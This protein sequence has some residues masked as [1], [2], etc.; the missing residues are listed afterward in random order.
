MTRSALRKAENRLLVLVVSFT[1]VGTVNWLDFGFYGHYLA[2]SSTS[3]VVVGLCSMR[4]DWVLWVYAALQTVLIA[5]YTG[6]F[7]PAYSRYDFLLYGE[8]LNFSLILLSY[9]IAIIMTCGGAIVGFAWNWFN[10]A[11]N[12]RGHSS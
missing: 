3:L 5:L 1:L 12:R 11:F 2:L 9:E 6:L 4:D 8:D 10:N 7:A